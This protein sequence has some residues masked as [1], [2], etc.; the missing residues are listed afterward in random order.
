M[1][2]RTETMAPLRALIV[3]DERLARVA[4]R[5]ELERLEDVELV[6]E[7][8]DGEEAVRAIRELDLDLVFLDVRMPGMDGFDVV[9]TVGVEVMPPVIFVTAHDEHA[10]RAFDV[11]AVDY[12]LKPVE[13]DRLETACRRVQ[14]R[15]RRG[16]RD[17]GERLAAV[18]DRLEA[19][20]ARATDEERAGEAARATL[21]RL[22]VE[23]GGRISFVDVSDVRWIESA[24]NYARLHTFGGAFLVRRTMKS[25]ERE[26]DGDV[27]LR[28]RRSAIVNMEHVDQIESGDDER[29]LVHLD[30]GTEL[31]SSRRRTGTIRRY[32]D[33]HR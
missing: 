23:K 20:E 10:T 32:I 11:N 13:P 25:L 8:S 18:L 14:D 4:I 19:L 2:R 6:G 31:R 21:H 5:R 7:C 17:V 29:F 26:L 24:G 33:R 22:A 3:D 28:V 1:D 16:D 15:L 30:D 27:F 12:V 9:R